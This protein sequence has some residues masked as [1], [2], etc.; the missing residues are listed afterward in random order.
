MAARA[1][2]ANLMPLRIRIENTIP[3]GAGLASSASS[4]AAL[5]TALARLLAPEMPDEEVARWARLGSGSAVRSL[6][7][8]YVLWE[9]GT[10]PAGADC[11]ARSILPPGH[12]PL[13]LVACIVDDRPKAIDST[14]AMERCRLTSPLF[15]DFHR[16]IPFEV[17]AMTAA[18]RAGDLAA[19]TRVAERNCLKMHEVLRSARPSIDF[20]QPAS[21]AVIGMVRALRGQGV[22]CFFT[23]DAG[24]NVKV[25]APLRNV[26][27]VETACAAVPG[28]QRTL[29]D[30]VG[31]SGDEP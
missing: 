20:L 3:T 31:P 14:T 17:V 15:D 24:P 13:G 18:L 25:F 23:I 27:T 12:L 9:A 1:S 16:E 6:H 8:G 22:E 2:T 28:V 29:L 5:A 4:M 19:I 11:R 10:D 7:P 21:I 26:P 30:R